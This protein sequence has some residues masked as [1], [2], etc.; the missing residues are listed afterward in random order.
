MVTQSQDTTSIRRYVLI[1][2]SHCDIPGVRRTGRTG[3][4]VLF[5][6]M[7]GNLQIAD[8]RQDLR[9]LDELADVGDTGDMED[10]SI[11]FVHTG[12]E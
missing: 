4:K 5:L 3:R 6:L 2:D 1:R 9:T 12:L 11:E 8:W 10:D 7:F